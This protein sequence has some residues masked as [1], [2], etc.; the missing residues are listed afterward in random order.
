MHNLGYIYEQ[1][2]VRI[3]SIMHIVPTLELYECTYVVFPVELIR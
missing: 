1:Y 2:Y 3:I